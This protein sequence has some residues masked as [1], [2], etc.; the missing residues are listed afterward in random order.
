MKQVLLKIILNFLWWFRGLFH[1][2]K[3]P[4]F[5]CD[6]NTTAQSICCKTEELYRFLD[7][8]KK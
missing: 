6:K 5:N 7:C 8:Y 2:G 1:Y 3:L 4:Y